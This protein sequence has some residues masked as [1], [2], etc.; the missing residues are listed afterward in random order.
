M[1]RF[2]PASDVATVG[3]SPTAPGP[4]HRT[5]PQMFAG[6]A[7]SILGVVPA[8]SG[9]EAPAGSALGPTISFVSVASSAATGSGGASTAGAAAAAAAAATAATAQHGIKSLK[10]RKENVG[11]PAGAGAGGNFDSVVNRDEVQSPAYSDISD[12]STPVTDANDANGKCE[13]V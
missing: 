4:L 6:A 9:G 2:G 11:A 12:D 7:G 13:R 5:T 10:K 1:L 3:M 8:M